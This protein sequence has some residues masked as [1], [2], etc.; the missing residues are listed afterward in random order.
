LEGRRKK[1]F[2][3]K[4][5]L[6]LSRRRLT[7]GNKQSDYFIFCFLFFFINFFPKVWGMGQ[8]FW[9]NG[10]TAP[11]FFEACPTLGSVQCSILRGDWRFHFFSIFIFSKL[12]VHLD[13]QIYRWDFG[14]MKN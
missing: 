12:R 6:A 13:F 2:K 4:G 1:K 11:P 14:F 3:K 10:C 9:E 5:S 8:G 7:A